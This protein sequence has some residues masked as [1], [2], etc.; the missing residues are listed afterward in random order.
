[1]RTPGSVDRSGPKRG[2]CPREQAAGDG[3]G[4]RRQDGKKQ[5]RQQFHSASA[6]AMASS[7]RCKRAALRELCWFDSN[8]MHQSMVSVVQSARTPECD[9]GG[10]GFEPRPSPQF[11]FRRRLGFETPVLPWRAGSRAGGGADPSC[12]HSST[13]QSAGIRLRRLEVRLLV[14][15]PFHAR[16][17]PSGRRHR[18]VEPASTGSNPVVR[19]SLRRWLRLGKPAC[20]LHREGCRAEVL[21]KVDA[22]IV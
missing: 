2:D 16:P 18:L 22:S 4:N 5:A 21:A 17:S 20:V 7:T 6:W 10:R 13:G 1:M 12:A 19:A 3:G 11:Q 15:A 14:S 8:P 9:S